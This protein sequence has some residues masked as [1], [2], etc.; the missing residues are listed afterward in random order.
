LDHALASATLAARVNRAG[1]WHINA[2]EGPQLDYNLELKAP[3]A[4]G[5]AT[6]PADPYTPSPFRS[7]D[8]DPIL[9]GL[10][11]YKTLTAAPGSTSLVGTPGDDILIS[12]AGRRSLTG[13][14]GRDQF[15]FVAG[16]AGGATITDLQ[17]GLDTIS[18]KAVLQGLGVNTA[19]PIANGQL[20]CS[21]AGS[22]AL[23]SVDTDAAG[24][25]A[26]RALVLIKAQGCAVLNTTNFTF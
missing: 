2:D 5:A 11:I 23:I 26:P 12:G 22:D 9:V 21:A 13:G 7:S 24:P 8:H 10:N 6:C 20:L 3:L 25:A 1:H 17:P 19:N 4:C 15:V 16:F 18:L 14:A